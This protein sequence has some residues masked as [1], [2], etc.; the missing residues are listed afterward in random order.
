MPYKKKTV[1][2]EN[3]DATTTAVTEANVITDEVV[4]KKEDATTTGVTDE[5]VEKK[6]KRKFEN[7]ETIP[8]VSITPGEMFFEGEKSGTLYTFADADY[9]VEIEY[10][11]LK[12]AV[13]RK[14]SMV[15]RPRF[16][17][18]DADF[19][20]QYPQ[21]DAV[22]AGLYSSRDLRD[23]LKGSPA[24]LRRII[25]TLPLGAQ[26]ALKHMAATMIDNGTLDSVQ[27]IKAL[28]D[29]FDTE[30]LLRLQN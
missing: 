23:M 25:P 12:Y 21:L 20:A 13:D 19:L 28:D 7:E 2:T 6:T 3:V 9:V 10:R 26:D 16:I 24:D 5:V 11:D 1:E 29:L 17:V 27:R 4:E 18:Q 8:C 15:F 30:M 22:Y 14:N